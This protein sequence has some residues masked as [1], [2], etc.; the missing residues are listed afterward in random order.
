MEELCFILSN[1]QQGEKENESNSFR[2]RQY[3]SMYWHKLPYSAV[4]DIW[5]VELQLK[6]LALDEKSKAMFPNSRTLITVSLWNRMVRIVVYV[7]LGS[8][9]TIWYIPRGS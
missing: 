4:W 8:T 2:E 3:T 5:S 1:S 6:E 9:Y 7:G